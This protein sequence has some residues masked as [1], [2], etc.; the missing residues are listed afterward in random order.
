VWG[1]CVGVCVCV[2]CVC[3][4]CGWVCVVVCACVR[5]RGACVYTRM[6]MFIHVCMYVCTWKKFRRKD[7]LSIMSG[8]TDNS[9]FNVCSE[10]H[11]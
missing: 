2:W 6:C 8:M 4:V 11:C 9:K 7:A 5:A 10:D 1:V 3:G